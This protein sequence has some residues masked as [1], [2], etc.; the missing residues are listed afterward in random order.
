MELLAVGDGLLQ[1]Q[2]DHGG[3]RDAALSALAVKPLAL[4][5]SGAE[6]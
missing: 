5:L 2:L 4:G 6:G 1:Q 3:H